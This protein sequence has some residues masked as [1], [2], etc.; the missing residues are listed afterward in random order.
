MNLTNMKIYDISMPIEYDMPVYKGKL[1]KRP[2][3]K[4]DSDFKQG[5]VYESRI[6][7]NLHT[8]THLDRTLHMIDGGNTMETLDIQD[9]V[10]ACKVIDLTMVQDKITA[11]DLRDKGIKECDFIL[12]KTKNSC[13]NILESEFVYLERTG[14]KYLAECN[15]KGVGIDA[16]GIERNQPEHETHLQLME[17]GIHI[18]E[19]L[20]LKEIIEGE[21][22]LVA[23]PINIIGAEA[24]PVRAILI[25]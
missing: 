1:E 9:L 4:V 14:A 11:E 18:L 12:L 2:L 17:K 3:L 22:L 25:K 15:I 13:E 24:A 20:R 8:G 21:Y 16:L 23:A 10:T 6:E 5:K 19:G 7:M